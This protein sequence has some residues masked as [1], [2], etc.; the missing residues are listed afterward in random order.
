MLGGALITVVTPFYG[1]ARQDKKHA[2]REPISARLMADLFAA[3]G[4]DRQA[5]NDLMKA[6]DIT[7]TLGV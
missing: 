3:A 2:G 6:C 1:Y 5:V 7:M 4:A